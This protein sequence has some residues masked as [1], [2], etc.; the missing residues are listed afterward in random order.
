MTGLFQLIFFLVLGAFS[1]YVVDI[2][3]ANES[4]IYILVIHLLLALGLYSST[5][6]IR[7]EDTKKNMRIIIPVITVGVLIKIGIISGVLFYFH[8]DPK[9][10]ILGIVVAQ[11]DPLSVAAILNNSRM[12]KRVR[13]ILASWASFDDP[14]TVLLSFY[15]SM[16][17]AYYMNIENTEINILNISDY[18]VNLG[19]NISFAIVTF[20]IWYLIRKYSILV[21]ILLGVVM[22]IAVSHFL[23]LGIALVGLFLRPSFDVFISCITKIALWTSTFMLGM[24]MLD[25]IDIINGFWLA[26]VTFIAQIV[27]GFLLTKNLPISDRIHLAFAQQNGVTAIILALTFEQIFAGIVAITA[28]AIFF[29]NLFYVMSNK[30]M[31]R[32]WYIIKEMDKK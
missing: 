1:A 18:A 2:Q 27:V 12:S 29:I 9:Y 7:L 15:A 23:M 8:N 6:S 26:I 14:I 10:L 21:Y 3:H 25:G 20:A 13:T 31:N 30:T 17:V 5:Y 4:E 32:Y 28:P 11:I 22:I 24:L 19:A 16:V